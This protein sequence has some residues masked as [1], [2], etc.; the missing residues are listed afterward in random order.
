MLQLQRSFMDASDAGSTEIRANRL[1][2]IELSAGTFNKI[3]DLSE[4]VESR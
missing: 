2:G 1:E 3:A 4:L